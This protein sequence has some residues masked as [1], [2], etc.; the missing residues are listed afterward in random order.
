MTT[1][2]PQPEGGPWSTIVSPRLRRV[3]CVEQRAVGARMSDEDEIL[4]GAVGAWGRWK[5]GRMDRWT[6]TWTHGLN[7]ACMQTSRREWEV[8]HLHM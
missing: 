6:H 5:E 2:M 3:V 8:T 4:M 1:S 7:I